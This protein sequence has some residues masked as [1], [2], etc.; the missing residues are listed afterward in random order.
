M[1]KIFTIISVLTGLNLLLGCQGLKH[2]DPADYAIA[3]NVLT[4]QENDNYEVFTMNFDGTEQQNISKLPGVEW[5]Y[6]SSGDKLYFI[7]DKDTC[8]RCYFLYETNYR[9]ENLRKVSDLRLADSWMDSRNDGQE[10]IIKP[11]AD[12]AFYI[13]D[14]KGTVINKIY[15]GLPYATDPHFLNDGKQIVFRGAYAKFKKNTSYIDELFIINEDGSGLRQL[16][17]YPQADTT[18]R[19]HNYHAGPPELHPTENFIS[20]HS[21]Q[22]GKYSLYAVTPDGSR[23]WKLTDLPQDEGWH[24][25]S[26]DGKWLA[27]ELFDTK[28]TQFYIGVLNWETK[29]LK[30]LTDSTYKYQQ[31]PNFVK[32]KP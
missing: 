24:D 3:F 16:T 23:Q 6:H 4:D 7:S 11:K 18:A 8:H 30:V 2:A 25:W 27:V 12:S 13:I 21:F 20:Y 22:N 19:W 15:T 26:P 29:E 28:Q 5:T 10:I 9:G 14:T 17:H 32:K 1:K 31:S